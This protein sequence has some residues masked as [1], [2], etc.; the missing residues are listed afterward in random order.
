MAVGL[1]GCGPVV[2]SAAPAHRRSRDPETATA[3]L[4][5]ATRFNIDYA[6]ARYAAVYGRF[7]AASRAV[8]SRRDYLRRHRECPSPKEGKVATTSV[9]RGPGR[10]WLVHYS[11]GGARLTDT[12]YYA[13]GR[14]AF[15][16]PRS[17]PSAVALYRSSPSAYARAVG[18]GR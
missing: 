3:L 8:I 17:N 13:G 15:D 16:L 10:A 5:I 4:R 9:T 11:I 6:T 12:W 18:C 7:D 1:A 2:P 14:F